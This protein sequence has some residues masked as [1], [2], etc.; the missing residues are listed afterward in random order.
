MVADSWLH[1]PLHYPTLHQCWAGLR[2]LAGLQPFVMAHSSAN[3]ATCALQ[4]INADVLASRYA[5]LSANEARYRPADPGEARRL[6][7]RIRKSGEYYATLSYH[8]WIGRGLE[9]YGISRVIDGCTLKVSHLN[10]VRR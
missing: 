9:P 4:R 2:P 1:Y 5:D 8:V 3:P 7:G 10:T 6:D